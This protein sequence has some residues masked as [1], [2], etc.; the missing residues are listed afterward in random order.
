MARIQKRQTRSGTPT[1]V[2]KWRT[3]DGHDRTKG[4]FRTRKA[5]QAY[6]TKVEA[7]KLRGVEFDPKA[8][9]ITFREAA[10]AWLASRHDL[11]PTTLAGYRRA[12]A[13]A[14]R[15]YGPSR[16]D[17]S[18]DATFGG[19]PLNAIKREQITAWVAGLTAAGKSPVT[20]RHAVLL[21]KQVLAQAVADK[22]LH[23]NPA[24]HV[25]L[26]GERGTRAVVDDP[27][28]FLTAAQVSA[29]VAATPWPYNVLVHVAAWAG[30]RAAEL[31]GLQ[32]GDVE[33]PEPALNPNAPRRPQQGHDDAGHL[34][35]PV[36]RR[37]LGG[38]DCSWR[39][40]PGRAEAQDGQRNTATRLGR[41]TADATTGE[42]G[43]ALP[44][45][46]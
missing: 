17:L 44:L 24:E 18:I 4:G 43:S 35:P 20:I 1:Y 5:A 16:Q 41:I 36:R 34:C 33:L 11:K 9:G 8:G 28:Q 22:R 40:G 39:H 42:G 19:Y 29:L 2:V 38:D 45:R 46:R 7:G 23:D 37:P 12:L 10:Q 31:A 30:L 27:A 13:P 26:P 14:Q 25:N 3:A 6:S 32:V 15:L 21:V